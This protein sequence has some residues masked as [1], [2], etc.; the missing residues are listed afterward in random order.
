NSGTTTVLKVQWISGGPGT[1]GFINEFGYN[2][3]TTVS[4]ITYNGAD[5]KSKWTI[6]G[7]ANIDGFGTFASDNGNGPTA[8]GERDGSSLPIVFTL[9]SEITSIPDNGNGAEFVAHVGGYSS[10]CSAFVSDGTS[11]SSTSNPSCAAV[12][13]PATLFLVGTGLAGFGFFGR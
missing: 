7:S 10:G 13:E 2:S 6:G 9:A 1:P 5:V 4:A 11:S 12:P 3:S 8:T